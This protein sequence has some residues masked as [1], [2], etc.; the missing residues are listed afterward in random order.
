MVLSCMRKLFDHA[1]RLYAG[2]GNDDM[3]REVYDDLLFSGAA[4]TTGTMESAMTFVANESV[5]IKTK[6]NLLRW[7]RE[8]M[9]RLKIQGSVE[10][11]W[12]L[13]DFYLQDEKPGKVLDLFEM[14]E[15]D[16]ELLPHPF[17]YNRA[18][19]AACKLR[20]HVQAEKIFE[21]MKKRGYHRRGT[22]ELM[23]RVCGHANR[24]DK[25]F[26]YYED[27][28]TGPSG[29]RPG[30]VS[31]MLSFIRSAGNVR[32]AVGAEAALQSKEALTASRLKEAQ[33]IAQFAKQQ[34]LKDATKVFESIPSRELN[35]NT[36][37]AMVLA[38]SAA[39]NFDGLYKFCMRH[40]DDVDDEF[41]SLI[42]EAGYEGCEDN[43][44]REARKGLW[45]FY[46]KG[47]WVKDTKAHLAYIRACC[48]A[49]AFQDAYEGLRTMVKKMGPLQNPSAIIGEV[50]EMF[51]K[52]E[53]ARRKV[54]SYFREVYPQGV[55]DMD[56]EQQVFASRKSGERAQEP[57]MTLE[58]PNQRAHNRQYARTT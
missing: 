43:M 48:R 13:M 3:M 36:I 37:G 10:T 40:E 25:A 24:L 31:L 16:R 38:Y 11:Y 42:V 46:S 20:S 32:Y 52:D 50:L 26:E 39:E 28:L 6:M 41:C 23:V 2:Q 27:L 57:P 14:Y 29:S 5:D 15:Q 22:I 55:V 9:G 21:K 53:D 45:D 8:E 12:R 35:V 18:F 1:I 54:L 30:M 34:R 17:V 7:V 19:R 58:E 49:L 51:S 4:P 56:S 33:I 47:N 44:N